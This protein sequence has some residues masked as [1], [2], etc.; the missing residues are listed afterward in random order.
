MGSAITMIA[1]GA[2]NLEKESFKKFSNNS[3]IIV[4]SAFALNKTPFSKSANH[5]ERVLKSGE[6]VGGKIFCSFFVS[7]L[8][9]KFLEQKDP[10]HNSIPADYVSAGHV[11]VSADRDRI[12]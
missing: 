9:I 6:M 12:C 3:C 2:S 5:G 11:L 10:P 4:G 1:L 8:N 7:D